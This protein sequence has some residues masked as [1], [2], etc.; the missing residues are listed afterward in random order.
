MCIRDSNEAQPTGESGTLLRAKHDRHLQD[1]RSYYEAEI[2][3]L[4]QAAH[5][6]AD[7]ATVSAANYRAPS[8]GRIPAPGSQSPPLRPQA[9]APPVHGS[10][11]AQH[12]DELQ[13]DKQ[14]MEAAAQSQA[15]QHQ[16][17][18]QHMSTQLQQL[19]AALQEAQA[20]EQAAAAAH[21]QS[22]HR[23]H[24]LATNLEAQRVA[25][26]AEVQGLA[27]KLAEQAALYAEA[28]AQ[29]ES[30][31]G[32]LSAVQGSM[33]VAEQKASAVGGEKQQV[34]TQLVSTQHQ[35]ELSLIHI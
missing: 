4:K 27:V 23:N 26:Q 18:Q 1:V 31:R 3:A 9:S 20:R 30:Q 12:I 5:N 21:E 24:E 14:S 17:E 22:N 6:A 29:L 28:C 19:S 32:Q 35:L 7:A 2:S 16:D 15:A 34:E 10:P 33:Q 11:L 8:Q 13:R 25:S